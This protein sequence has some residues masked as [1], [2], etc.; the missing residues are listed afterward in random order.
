MKQSFLYIIPVVVLV[1]V[2]SYC[3]LPTTEVVEVKEEVIAIERLSSHVD[4]LFLNHFQSS[5]TLIT[6]AY[7]PFGMVRPSILNHCSVATDTTQ[8]SNFFFKGFQQIY[9]GANDIISD[10]LITPGVENKR[11]FLESDKLLKIK[12]EEA[13]VGFHKLLFEKSNLS[14]EITATR[15]VGF[16]KLQSRNAKDKIFLNID[17]GFHFENDIPTESSLRI[18]NDSTLIGYRISTTPGNILVPDERKIY[19]VIQFSDAWHSYNFYREN[20]DIGSPKRI[21]AARSSAKINFNSL[22]SNSVAMKVAVSTVSIDGA[23]NNLLQEIPHWDFDLVKKAA[24]GVWEQE[25]NRIH[26]KVKDSL[27]KKMFYSGLFNLMQTP[28]LI[29][30]VD[31]S[32]A[33][34]TGNLQ[35]T[36]GEFDRYHN[37]NTACKNTYPLFTL[38]FADKVNDFVK[39]LLANYKETGSFPETGVSNNSEGFEAISIIAEAYLK[40]IGDFDVNLAYSTIKETLNAHPFAK[41]LLKYKYIP[42]NFSPKNSI[43]YSLAFA[44]AYKSTSLMAQ[45]MGYQQDYLSFSTCSSM[46]KYHFDS[47]TNTIRPRDKEGGWADEVDFELL[48]NINTTQ[49]RENLQKTW[50]IR[51]DL[52]GIIDL[53]RG[54]GNFIVMLDSFMNISK[55][56]IYLSDTAFFEKDQAIVNRFYTAETAHIPYLYTYVGESWKTQQLIRTQIDSV[57]SDITNKRYEVSNIQ[58]AWLIFNMLGIYPVN[59]VENNYILGSPLVEEALLTINNNQLLKIRVENQNPRQFYVKQLTLNNKLFNS[60]AIPYSKFLY[61]GEL[62]FEMQESPIQL[63]PGNKLKLLPDSLNNSIANY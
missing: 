30:D 7:L 48:G 38:F 17:P 56:D 26:I 19:F 58:F 51:H 47:L 52:N 3:S 20:F 13:T 40:G 25:L 44:Q 49:H 11:L 61:G 46:Y 54:R 59:S 21:K 50:S 43:N 24:E 23:L 45:A 1:F 27:Y 14:V 18:L 32:Y 41:H 57:F 42:A 63:N 62:V 2:I 4:P 53:M 28:R 8:N 22:R 6:G 31:G 29:S 5:N 10:F 35:T 12:N 60:V 16:Y 37:F 36:E 55:S 15:R 9:S 39:S 34:V 33:D